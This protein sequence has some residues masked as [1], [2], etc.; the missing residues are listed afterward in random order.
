MNYKV[1]YNNYNSVFA[2]PCAVAQEYIKMCS[3]VA[4]KT[5]MVILSSGSKI[6]NISEISKVIGYSEEDI[7]DG[8]NFWKNCGVLC[9]ENS[10]NSPKVIEE[11]NKETEK[12]S[13]KEPVKKLGKRAPIERREVLEYISRNSE[14]TFL[15]QD[16]QQLSG[17]TLTSSDMESLVALYTYYGLSIDYIM[18][19]AHYCYSKGKCSMKYVETTVSSWLDLGVNTHEKLD[20][21][22]KKLSEQQSEEN[23]IKSAFGISGRS[24]V[25]SEKKAAEKWIHDYKFDISMIKLAYERT[26][27]RIGKLSFSYIDK[28]LES[29]N[30]E[31]IRTP[32]DAVQEEIN[33]KAAALEG[34]QE[35][36]NCGGSDTS[37][38]HDDLD[39]IINGGF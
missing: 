36:N 23:L 27:E 20:A 24:L 32:K 28:I 14:L 31:N 34:K 11:N 38:T 17:K 4:L 16:F 21:H 9:D 6:P 5:L 3:G 12:I 30:K 7:L 35:I 25:T 33:F 13:Y 39:D 22:I 1:N 29:W 19:A 15:V 8:I 2:V 26:I 37:Y 10:E 18:M